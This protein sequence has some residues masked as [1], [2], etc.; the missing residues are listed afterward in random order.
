MKRPPYSREWL[1]GAA[2]FALTF[3]AYLPALHGSF[4]WD[5]SVMVADNQMLR[6]A[7][8]LHDFWF[9][10]RAVDP[11]PLTMSALW[12]QWHFWDGNRFGYHVAGVLAHILGALLLWRVLLRFTSHPRL[13][14]LAAAIFALHPVGVASVA[15]ISEQKNTLSMIF[16]LLSILCYLHFAG[17]ARRGAYWLA[18][19][20]YLCALLSKGSVVMLPV[21][22]LLIMAWQ[23]SRITGKD[24]RRLIPFF[25]LSA[26]AGL[27]TI[28]IQN[29]KAI[30][31]EMVQDIHGPARLAA[32][33]RAVWFYLWKGL[34]PLDI[35]VIYPAWHV[36]AGSI[37]AW[38][39]AIALAAVFVLC[40]RYRKSWGR[41]VL[42]GLGCFVVTLFPV[43]G[44]FDMYF[45][46]YSRVADHWQ[47]LALPALIAL[48]VCG[49]GYWFE[50]VAEKFHWPKMTGP[51]LAAALLVSLFI[52]TWTRAGVYT[53]EKAIWTDTTTKNPNAWMAWNN[54][55][56]ALATDGDANAAI[57]A[58]EKAI[59]VNPAFPD[60][61]S[62]LGNALVG[63]G[64]LAEAIA[65]LQKAVEEEPKMAKFHFNYGVGLAGLGKLDEAAGQYQQAL[66]LRPGMADVRNNLANIL[67]EQKKFGDALAMAQSAMQINPDMPE[68]YLNA[69]KAL[70][71]LER[72]DEAARDFETFLQLRP[73]D[74][75][76]HFEY[77]MMLA[78]HGNLAAALPHFQ[79]VVR[80]KPNEAAGHGSLGNTLAGLKRLPEA[81]AEFRAALR[82][83]P[84][85]AQNHNNLA[86]ALLEQGNMDEAIEHYAT[87]VKLKADD[88]GTRVN[89][90]W[91]LLSRGRREEAIAQYRE[92]LRLKPGDPVIQQ[93]LDAAL[94]Q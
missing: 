67:Y 78:M 2:L 16:Y 28:W 70:S 56:N 77:G 38:L 34:V 42:L 54:L 93:R 52:S 85:D 62:N 23:H 25:V 72:T 8:G 86:N 39:P 80:L 32:A 64:Q 49:G 60:A 11:L 46:V 33:A 48:A 51:A 61:E 30:A 79:T 18:L 76:A 27:A 47:Y 40:W 73:E 59:A 35:C 88:P 36:E 41:H 65:H 53:S 13:A 6:T 66:A 83:Q 20:L 89:F 3:L 15:W 87:A 68:P 14:W 91:A 43:M 82:L 12:L 63:K 55:G 69:A 58:Y 4:I 75:G 24:F 44:F 26:G 5:D 90:A 10:T 74:A 19:F 1:W 21:V 45:L 9:T 17:G 71:A 81:A 94:R 29:H 37:A 22:L 92:A 7:R 57:A 84:G 50:R 31:G